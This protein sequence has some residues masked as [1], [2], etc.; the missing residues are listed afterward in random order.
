M[1]TD[2]AIV[3]QDPFLAVIKM[4]TD[5]LDSAHSV[6]AYTTALLDFLTWRQ[7]H[8]AAPMVK[9]TVTAYKRHL[10][11]LGLSSSTIN[12]RLSAVRKLMAE[13]AD[14]GL[15]ATADATAIGRVKG[16]KRAGRRAGNWLTL[17][18]AQTLLD[19]PDVA[20]VKGLRDRAILAV[21]LGAGLRRSECAALEVRHLAT[22]D[23]RPCLVDLH[24]KGGR[25]RT[26]P[27]AGWVWEALRAWIARAGMTAGP[28]FVGLTKSH[29]LTTRA[30]TPQAIMLTVEQYAPA[31]IEPHDLRRSFAKL[32]YQGGAALDQVS[33][34]LGHASLTT[35]ERYLGLEQHLTNGS[36]P[37][38]RIGLR[39]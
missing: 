31:G 9:A 10:L 15:L 29:G 23:G 35:T 24:G 36:A 4:A 32:S 11:A 6:R 14:N 28:V 20:T 13:A 3:E 22:R 12:L 26:V 5:S 18:Q 30:L 1:S 25:T 2:L 39:V 19:A 16:V 27:V 38:D 7:E 34:S 17:E 37:S 21:L 8:G 33:L